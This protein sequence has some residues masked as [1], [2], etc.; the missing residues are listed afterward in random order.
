[1]SLENEEEWSN[2]SAIFSAD[3]D[4][5]MKAITNSEIKSNIGREPG[6]EDSYGVIPLDQIRKQETSKSASNE[7][8]DR[9]GD[10]PGETR[11]SLLEKHRSSPSGMSL[12]R[13]KMLVALETETDGE[14]LV[15]GIRNLCKQASPVH[16]GAGAP[17]I[18][19]GLTSRVKVRLNWF[20]YLVS[21]TMRC[22]IGLGHSEKLR[23]EIY[24]FTMP[25]IEIYKS[26]NPSPRD[27]ERCRSQ[28]S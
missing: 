3:A 17:A 21:G 23:K 15:Q 14:K 2:D 10:I 19:V 26:G 12:E 27:A 9:K 24:Q 18:Q 5:D 11:V 28:S 25:Q 7:S 16:V 22:R 20:K 6:D 13:N 1:M 4:S 8:K